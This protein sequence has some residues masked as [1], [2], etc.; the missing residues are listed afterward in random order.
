MVARA[1]GEVHTCGFDAWAMY[2]AVAVGT[3]LGPE[4]RRPASER[5]AANQEKAVSYAEYR[6]LLDLFPA[7]TD[8]MR[9]RM[10]SLGYDPDDASTDPTTP[11]GIGNVCAQAV[12]AFRHADG[13]NQ[14]GDLHAGAYS[15]YTGYQPVNTVDQILD[16]NRWQPLR[17]CDGQGGFVTPGFIAPH[18]GSVKPFA[19]GSWDQFAL[20]GP[21]RWKG[22]AYVAQAEEIL[23]LNAHLDDREKMIAE[24]WADG[25]RSELPPGHWTLFAEW[26]SARDHHTLDQDVK[27]FFA[28]G[29]AVM[30]AGIAVWG[31]KRHY[32]SERPITAIRFLKRGKRVL[33][34]V[35]FEGPRVIRGEDWTPYQ[36]CSSVTPPFAEY[37]SGHSAFSAAG[38]EI[39]KRFTGSDAFGASVTFAPGSGRLE[40]G[41][42]PARDVTL[43][44]ATFSEAADEAG[45]SRRLGGI[46]FEDG[47]LDSRRLGRQ[48]GAAVWERVEAHVRGS[49]GSSGVTASETP[50]P[51]SACAAGTDLGI[52][53]VT[54]NPTRGAATVDFVVAEPGEV[55]VAVLDVQGREVAEL[56]AGLRSP[57]RH[58]VSWGRAAGGAPRPGIYFIRYQT[59]GRILTRRLVVLE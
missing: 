51:A 45:M 56:A 43:S 26:V 23:R 27:L 5:T 8:F 52:A 15:D 25:P 39:L 29:N 2:D 55:R 49:V 22:G 3:R 36:P 42:A 32:D 1:I 47:D 44:W 46:H 10:A 35:P 7:L 31:A 18:W 11:A 28:L 50:A 9:E 24:Y 12:I 21:A 37:P 16:P 58:R 33:T 4:F 40:P 19:L 34:Y 38:A 59:T 6:A 17:L 14:L 41:F 20:P 54:P 30:D 48:V 13:S 53:A 57:G